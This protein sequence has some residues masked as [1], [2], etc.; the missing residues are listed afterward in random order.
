ME[1]RGGYCVHHAMNAAAIL[2]QYNNFRAN[3]VPSVQCIV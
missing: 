3:T 1:R 2:G